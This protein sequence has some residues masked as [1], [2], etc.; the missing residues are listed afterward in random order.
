MTDEAEVGP[1]GL[2]LD[3][4]APPSRRGPRIGALAAG[5]L[6]LAASAAL[7]WWVAHPQRTP[8]PPAPAPPPRPA[9][10]S[11][12][13]RY[14]SDEPD[15][16]QVRRAYGDVQKAF[17]EG[18]PDAL[19]QAS[20]ACAS[21]APADPGR[22]DYCLAF[23]DYAA[24]VVRGARDAQAQ[25]QWFGAAPDRDLALARSVLP[26]DVDAGNRLAQVSALT[27][28]VLPKPKLAH[29]RPHVRPTRARRRAEAHERPRARERPGPRRER[30]P[31]PHHPLKRA[32]APTD[33][34]L[35]PY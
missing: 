16:A 31:A 19:V 1:P 4:D 21:D 13:L 3:E 25:T 18:G 11:Q 5:F 23:D 22:L 7:A 35:P 27:T 26:Q 28:A 17:A 32:V 8:A 33:D 29:P 20:L 12:P 15:P 14:A 2:W 6:A 24:L 9:A 10:A 30:R 34:Q